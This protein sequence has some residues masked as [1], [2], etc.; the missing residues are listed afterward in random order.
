MYSTYCTVLCI[1]AWTGRI[2]I[3]LLDPHNFAGSASFC[4]IHIILLELHWF[5]GSASFCFFSRSASFCHI[6]IN[7]SGSTSFCRITTIVKFET[8]NCCKQSGTALCHLRH[9]LCHLRPILCHLRPILCHL[10][11]IL[12]QHSI[13][14]LW[15]WVKH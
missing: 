5:S 3:I 13:L 14:N 8:D 11:P 15:P 4:R 10:R 1:Y 9:I 6:H 7:L 12:W 2:C